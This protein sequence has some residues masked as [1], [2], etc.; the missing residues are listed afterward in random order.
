ML[1]SSS[2]W[3]LFSEVGDNWSL[4]SVFAIAGICIGIRTDLGSDIG[5]GF[6]LI[7]ISLENKIELRK[8]DLFKSIKIYYLFKLY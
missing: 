1:A 8:S 5:A 6:S 3:Y 7:N 4:E 2:Y